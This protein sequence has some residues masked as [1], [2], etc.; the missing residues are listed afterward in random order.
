MK[1]GKL[2]IPRCKIF[3]SGKYFTLI[4]LLVV[5]AIISILASLLL[6]ALQNAKK[7]ARTICC[8]SNMKTN[9]FGVLS[10]ADD[11][12]DYVVPGIAQA[13]NSKMIASW[14][15]MTYMGYLKRPV[16]FTPFATAALYPVYRGMY[17][18][19]SLL[20]PE[21]I[22]FTDQFCNTIPYGTANNMFDP[23]NSIPQYS[24][25]FYDNTRYVCSYSAIYAYSGA[26]YPY[27]A[28]RGYYDLVDDSSLCK[29]SLV[30]NPGRYV[31]HFEGP[32]YNSSFQWVSA[33]H[34]RISNLSF[35][36]GHVESLP[37]NRNNFPLWSDV[38]DNTAALE[39]S[40]F[41]WRLDQ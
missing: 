6:P 30:P 19:T 13:P 11:N 8:L 23:R 31:M 1:S 38:R 26:C 24:W 34:S 10:Y 9:A 29:L 21:G 7:K 27:L 12:G 40:N 35:F 16:D 14:G 20:C 17:S 25:I 33:N 32:D 2:L 15:I 36:D 4:E 37:A 28:F 18:N 3:S 39:N 41:L 5:I 22:N